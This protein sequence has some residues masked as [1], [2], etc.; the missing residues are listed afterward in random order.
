MAKKLLRV[1]EWLGILLG[2]ALLVAVWLA[3]REETLQWAARQLAEQTGGA[4]VLEDVRGSLLGPVTVGRVRYEDPDL[5]ITAEEVEI[6]WEPVALLVRPHRVRI[7]DVEVARLE[8]V[9]LAQTEGPS[10]PPDTLRVP[11]GIAVDRAA[12]GELVY[13]SGETRIES[14]Q[15]RLAFEVDAQFHRLTIER[16]ESE[17]G[18][19]DGRVTVGVDTPFPVAGALSLNGRR[20]EYPYHVRATVGGHAR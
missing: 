11:I 3:T 13:A 7:T 6:Q 19:L 12:I 4:V 15:V 2:V 10:K 18:V 8:I 14:R 17:L 1:V 16:A 9:S 20:D 5:R